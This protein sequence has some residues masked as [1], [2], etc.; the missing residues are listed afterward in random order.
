MS[1][2]TEPSTERGR[3]GLNNTEVADPGRVG[4]VA[5][6]SHPAH[7]RRDLLEEIQPFSAHTEIEDHEAS[8][9]A[10]RSG[11]TIN[12][13]RTDRISHIHEHDRHHARELLECYRP[14]GARVE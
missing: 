14:L 5:K 8:Y 13:A 3:H 6:K 2:P 11:Q 10:T 12:D 1:M 7:V 9:V 4:F